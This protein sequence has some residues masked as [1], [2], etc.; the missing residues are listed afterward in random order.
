MNKLSE[1]A[2]IRLLSQELRPLAEG[3][4]IGR[5]DDC[6]VLA[7]KS[8][9]DWL[10]T[11]DAMFEDVHFRRSFMDMA[12]LARKA[13]AINLSDI[14][15]MGGKARYYLLSVAA[16]EGLTDNDARAMAA[17]LR[18]LEEKYD[19]VC[20]GGNTTRSASG[21]VLSITAIGQV[22]KG[23]ALLRSQAKLGDAIYVSGELGSS[24]LGLQCLL[25]NIHTAEAKPFIDVHCSPEPRLALGEWL[26]KT[27]MVTS[28]IDVSDG[29]VADL[30]HIADQSRVG[31]EI[32]ADALPMAEGFHETCNLL[33]R[34][35]IVLAATGGEDY[36]LC[37]TV[38]GGKKSAFEKRCEGKDWKLSHIGTILADEKVRVLCDGTGNPITYGQAG[39]DHFL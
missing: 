16:P 29:L 9:V 39:F 38:V 15:A 25:Q 32:S 22:P 13:L 28:M 4:L 34:D 12:T 14:A 30:G 2:F 27:D 37:F 21:L 35:P 8:D 7:G 5:G 11:T 36:E 1:H 10:Y 19:V 33:K 20:I 24:A 23:A 26:R 31:F 6:A 18:C 17:G 3:V